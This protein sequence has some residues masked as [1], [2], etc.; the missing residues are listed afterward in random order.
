MFQVSVDLMAS[1]MRYH[2]EQ[3]LVSIRIRCSA[4]GT[5]VMLADST[6]MRLRVLPPRP[7]T[8]WY[9]VAVLQ[10]AGHRRTG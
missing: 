4:C 6:P 10:A 3:N 7:L 5:A 8:P 1:E 2:F 9:S